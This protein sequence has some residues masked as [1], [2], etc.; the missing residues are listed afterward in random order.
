V[1]K[2]FWRREEVEQK[3][4]KEAKEDEEIPECIPCTSELT[5]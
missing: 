3:V 2:I 4:A 5:N 1:F